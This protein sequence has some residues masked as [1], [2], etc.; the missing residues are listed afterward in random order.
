MAKLFHL[1]FRVTTLLVVLVISDLLFSLV[2]LCYTVLCRV[3]M[4]WVDLGL[5]ILPGKRELE[6]EDVI[7]L[8]GKCLDHIVVVVGGIKS[9]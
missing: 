2:W 5:L 7:R 8:M 3:E 9:T 1:F 6:S 4:G